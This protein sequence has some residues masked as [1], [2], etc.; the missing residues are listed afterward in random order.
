MD[1]QI[2]PAMT[3][4]FTTPSAP[5]DPELVRQIAAD[6]AEITH[7]LVP[8]LH[9]LRDRFGYIDARAIP[10]IAGALNLSIEEVRAIVALGKLYRDWTTLRDRE[11]VSVGE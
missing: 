10:V 9:A 11:P 2:Y 6:F 5:F 7:P 1:R 8:V 4:T 3:T